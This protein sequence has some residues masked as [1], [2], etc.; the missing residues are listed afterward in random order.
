MITGVN[1]RMFTIYRTMEELSTN[2]RGFFMKDMDTAQGSAAKKNARKVAS[3][4]DKL[5]TEHGSE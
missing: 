1:Q 2:L 5:I 3:E 4:T